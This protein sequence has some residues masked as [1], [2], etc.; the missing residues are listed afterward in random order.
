MTSGAPP[1]QVWRVPTFVRRSA[2]T[3]ALLFVLLA[4]AGT[5][6]GLAVPGAV[7]LWLVV[8]LVVLSVWRWYLVPYVALTA[9]ALVV[10]GV[11]AHRSVGYGSISDAR[12]GL[13]G[14]KIATTGQGHVLAW[15]VQKSKL[16]EWSHAHTRADD[17]VDEIML[18]VR[19]AR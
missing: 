17:V 5:A 9:N 19:A 14:L 3:V 4:T 10:R 15:A 13:Y 18:R 2:V 7:L 11:F 16:A 1:T 8:V 12:P 6:I